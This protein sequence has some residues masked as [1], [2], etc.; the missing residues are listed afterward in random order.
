MCDSALRK[1]KSSQL[2]GGRRE[3][4]PSLGVDWLVGPP[5]SRSARSSISLFHCFFLEIR[6]TPEGRDSSRGLVFYLLAPILLPTPPPPLPQTFRVFFR[7]NFSSSKSRLQI[8][9][10]SLV[11]SILPF[12]RSSFK[13]LMFAA[14]KKSV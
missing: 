11:P 5:E 8:F 1:K 2:G 7:R 6:P 10:H 4:N 12:S 14:K 3:K 9:F 13:I